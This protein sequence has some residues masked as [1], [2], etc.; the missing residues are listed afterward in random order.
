MWGVVEVGGGSFSRT[1]EPDGP[2]FLGPAYLSVTS[3]RVRKGAVG[4]V[5]KTN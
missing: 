1:D 3:V 5:E 2:L 4:A